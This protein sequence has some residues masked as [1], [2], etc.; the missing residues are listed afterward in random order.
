MTQFDTRVPA[1]GPPTGATRVVGALYGASPPSPVRTLW[2]VLESTA[3]AFPQAAAI[4]DGRWVLNY[5]SL[6]RR[7]RRMGSCLASMGVG[8]GDRVGVRITSGTADLYLAILAILSVGAAYVP[9][10][11]DDP[12]DRAELVWSAADVCVIAG[13]GGQLTRRNVRLAGR[14]ARPP[15]PA[16]DAWIIFTSG[17]TGTPKGVAV[18]HRSA[19]AFVDAEARLFLHDDP[20]GP[21][22]RVLAGLSVAFDASC[23]EMWLAWR[24]GACLVPAPRAV[25]RT[26][27]E[28]VTW[29]ARRRIS[30]VSTVPTLASL[31]PAESLP[32]IRLLVLG[33][34]ACPSA[35]A[36]RLVR[37]GMEVWNTYGP[38]EGTVVACGTRLRAGEPVRIGLPLD[39]WR[40]AV[41]D[42]ASGELVSWGEEGELVIGG[43]GLARYLDQ[44]KDAV[45]FRPLETLGWKRAYRT[46]DLVR[47]DPEGL[48]YL[49]RADA[50]LKI[51]GYRVEPG[52]IENVLMRLPGIAAAAVTTWEP[53]PGVVELAAYYTG[54]DQGAA[55]DRQA[56]REYL[57]D[58]LPRHMVPAYLQCLPEMPLLAGGKVDRRNLPAPDRSG[59]ATAPG[60]YVGPATQGERALAG[61][62]ADLLGLERVSVDSQFFDDLGMSSLLVAHFCA[63][64]REQAEAPPVSVKDVYLYPTI[65][66]L[67]AAVAAPPALSGTALPPD[68]AVPRATTAQ[69]LACGA[70]QLLAFLASVLLGATVLV[71]G[72][73]WM[74][75]TAGLADLYL[76]SLAFGSGAFVLLCALPIL[77]KWTLVGRWKP[78]EI[79]VWSPSY[80]RFWLVKTLIQASPLALFAGS[81]VYSLYLRALGARIGRRVVILS[82]TV[83]VCTDML[84]IG[85]DTVIMRESSFT[86]YRAVSGV[87]QTGPVSIGREALIGEHTLLDIGTSLGDRCQLGHTSSLHED[88][89]VPD[90]QHWHGSPAQ[91]TS[92]DY[93]S[94]E[95]VPAGPLRR[96]AYAASQVIGLIF[97]TVPLALAASV[98]VLTKVR[99]VVSLESLGA[100]GLGRESFYTDGLV[101]ATALFGGA[102]LLEAAIAVTVPRLLRRLV[103]PGRS[104]PLYGLRHA[105]HRAIRR[106]TNARFLLELTGDSSYV[107]HY[108]RAIGYRLP[109][110]QQTGSNFG[111]E[112]EHETPFLIDIG[113]GTMVSDGATFVN[114]GYTSTSFAV[115]PLSVGPGS[116]L[117]TGVAYPAGGRVG[118]NCMI[119]TRAMV[120]LDGPVRDGVGLLGSPSFEIPRSVTTDD[121]FDHLRTGEEFRRRLRAKNRHN[122]VTMGVF[123]AVRWM[124][125]FVITLFAMAAWEFFSGS[126]VLV[127]AGLTVVTLLFVLGYS[128]IIER[129]LLRFGSLR[130]RYCSIYDPYFWWHERYWKLMA[131]PQAVGLFNGTPFKSL[132]WRLLGVRV[133]RRV[134]DD[135]CSIP[136]RTLV[137]IG[138][139]CTLGAG[140]MIQ[141]HSMEDGI[142][143]ADHT[144]LEDGCTLGTDTLVHYGVTIG[145]GARLRPDSFL[146]K[147]EDVPPGAR[148]GGNPARAL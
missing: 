28:L 147:G 143:K 11:A 82:G 144:V 126:E 122:L 74:S 63:R 103:T 85:D 108:L 48:V 89:A 137:T 38:T 8:A 88:Q 139:D 145:N 61:A 42:P 31:W 64:A 81:P 1:G 40:L 98:A 128:I 95:P 50:Q 83:P 47:A 18:T 116:F 142:F 14:G 10:D 148:W 39:G 97:V 20:L 96:A 117:G 16:D 101:L 58:R 54:R 86:G 94:A 125:A 32:G 77:V 67:A 34:E 114:A 35:L 80:L 110:L 118:E 27:P 112:M 13:D 24:H 141:C 71:S 127:T 75:R 76:R 140:S 2:H 60:A 66:S 104:Y 135:G 22:D 49:G 57:G 121:R 52:E 4:D 132:V 146:M 87:I 120:P 133:G 33:G 123:L 100:G 69:Y 130:P 37:A 51:R 93:R 131:P 55:P 46:G 53:Q 29:L 138:N 45:A 30:A 17:T 107:V 79:S 9:V 41:V 119:A 3:Q 65:R 84:S 15:A 99:A 109:G 92:V 62:L 106:L 91:R 68:P 56:V 6:L 7:V 136:E 73:N 102:I 111:A 115:L 129:A 26:G 113:P 44:G 105:A 78:R 90:G 43:A 36:D 5:Q 70:V 23:E 19:A 134:F 25:V 12:P 124:E 21:G 59:R 72:Y